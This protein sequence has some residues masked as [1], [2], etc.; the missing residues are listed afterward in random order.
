MLRK[1]ISL[2]QQSHKMNEIL[3]WKN[4]Y[5]ELDRENS[6][7]R[8]LMNAKVK[9][10]EKESEISNRLRAK[11]DAI[12]SHYTRI[13]PST[14]YPHALQEFEENSSRSRSRT[15]PMPRKLDNGKPC[16]T[17]SALRK[18][19]QVYRSKS[20]HFGD[21][22]LP[23]AMS[24]FHSRQVS[25]PPALPK[26]TRTRTVSNSKSILPYTIESEIEDVDA[27]ISKL[28]NDAHTLADQMDHEERM[29][30]AKLQVEYDVWVS[31]K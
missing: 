7:T 22:T 11:I 9:Q 6:K 26:S 27:M 30:L 18:E 28:E 29:R 23:S 24:H 19:G 3:Y 20:E 2:D 13:P 14:F 12:S 5:K 25:Q 16:T 10:L 15:L 4:K 31:G 1:G 21:A 8:D 17:T